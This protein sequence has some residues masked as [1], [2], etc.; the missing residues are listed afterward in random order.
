MTRL[1]ER[2]RLG[3]TD[4]KGQPVPPVPNPSQNQAAR[5]ALATIAEGIADGTAQ[6][7]GVPTFLDNVF[8]QVPNVPPDIQTAFHATFDDLT[9]IEL[10]KFARM[11]NTMVGLHGRGYDTLADKFNPTVAKF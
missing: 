4:V 8:Q 10:Q 3:Q 6:Q 1:R 2:E 7:V 11:Q 5:R 9:P